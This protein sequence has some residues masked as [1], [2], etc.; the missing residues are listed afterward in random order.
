MDLLILYLFQL[1]SG[2]TTYRERNY[3]EGYKLRYNDTFYNNIDSLESRIHPVANNQIAMQCSFV[4]G[5][6][7]VNNAIYKLKGFRENDIYQF[8]ADVLAQPNDYFMFDYRKMLNERSFKMKMERV[9]YS[10]T[11]VFKKMAQAVADSIGVESIDMK[12][13]LKEKSSGKH[14]VFPTQCCYWNSN[15]PVYLK[16]IQNY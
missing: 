5:Y 8:F 2:A 7:L 6:N 10:R 11:T 1:P 15:K 14:I 3:I 16:T 4:V 12:N 13:I 9:L